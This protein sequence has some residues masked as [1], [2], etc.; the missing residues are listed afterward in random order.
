M[1]IGGPELTRAPP[2][3]GEHSAE[4]LAELGYDATTIEALRA[5]GV[6]A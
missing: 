1:S 3:H 6:I 2:R 5:G 4:V